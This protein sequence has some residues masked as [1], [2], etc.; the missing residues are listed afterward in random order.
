MSV[1]AT[2][3]PIASNV[4]GGLKDN[5]AFFFSSFSSFSSSRACIHSTHS[6]QC[7][8]GFMALSEFIHSTR[9]CIRSHV[10]TNRKYRIRRPRKS[11]MEK[12]EFCAVEG[13]RLGS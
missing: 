11:G 9:F 12:K 2:L 1:M 8:N 10:M 4:R 13:D 6:V 7:T 5:Y 3:L